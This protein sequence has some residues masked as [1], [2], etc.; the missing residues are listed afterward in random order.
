MNTP[1][2]IEVLDAVELGAP[3]ACAVVVLFPSV[4]SDD[5]VTQRGLVADNTMAHGHRFAADQLRKQGM[6]FS[7][8][9]FLIFGRAPRF[10]HTVRS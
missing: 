4:V 2:P 6:C 7:L 1:T 9:Y 10:S 8:A 5:N 3:R